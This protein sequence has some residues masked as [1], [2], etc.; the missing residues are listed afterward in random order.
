MERHLDG[1]WLEEN[2][3]QLAAGVNAKL[4]H[5]ARVLKYFL[6]H[7]NETFKIIIFKII[8]FKMYTVSSHVKK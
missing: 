7:K 5:V 8:T 4:I 2:T 3:Q 6:R 1:H